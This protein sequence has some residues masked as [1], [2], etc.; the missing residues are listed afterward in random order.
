MLQMMI[1]FL[2]ATPSHF[3]A[4]N[5]VFVFNSESDVD[6]PIMRFRNGLDTA[7]M[8]ASGFKTNRILETLGFHDQTHVVVYDYSKPSLLLRRRMVENWDGKDFAG[9]LAAAMPAVDAA[10][11]KR[12]V[13]IP[14]AVTREPAAVAGEFMR[15]MRTV[16]RSMDHWLAHWERYRKLPHS[17]VHIDVLREQEAMAA[18]LKT[19]GKGHAAIWM[20]DMFNSPNAVGKFSFDRRRSAYDVIPRTLG[21]QT[22]SYLVIGNEPRLW[23]AG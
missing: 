14:E 6:I 5:W 4:P 12:A 11:E 1:D 7:F 18:M 8:L 15:E 23:L 17:Y 21:A 20:S 9:F 13:Y 16:F 19:H 2:R 3:D 10:S 22:D